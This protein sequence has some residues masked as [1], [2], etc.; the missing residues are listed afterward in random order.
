MGCWRLG[1]CVQDGGA[2]AMTPVRR[3][4]AWGRGRRLKE[5]GVS[6]LV[7]AVLTFGGC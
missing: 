2:R 3:W 5:V 6:W 4:G 1:L 7:I